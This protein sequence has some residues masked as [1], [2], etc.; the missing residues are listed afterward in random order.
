[1]ALLCFFS[2]YLKVYKTPLKKP[3]NIVHYPVINSCRNI[4]FLFISKILIIHLNGKL[5]WNSNRSWRGP[6]SAAAGKWQQSSQIT[7]RR[8]TKYSF[9]LPA[10]F[11]LYQRVYSPPSTSEGALLLKLKLCHCK[12]HIN[13]L[14]LVKAKETKKCRH[15]DDDD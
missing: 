6:I 3:T 14:L 2:L 13:Y 10:S 4:N 11:P 8:V 5:K 9:P 15:R 1:M 12:S 7:R